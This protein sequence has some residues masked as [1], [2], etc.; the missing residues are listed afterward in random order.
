MSEFKGEKPAQNSDKNNKRQQ[1]GDANVSSPTASR[2]AV[3][4]GKIISITS[5]MKKLK[6]QKL[7]DL[8]GKL[9][10]LQLADSNK[11]N[12]NL[13]QEIKKLQI[14]DIY[15]LETQKRFVFLKQKNYEV[16]GKSAKLLA[17]KLRKQEKENTIY[18]I[19][20]LKTRI[21]RKFKRAL[22]YF[23][24]NYILNPGLQ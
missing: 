22:K 14:D 18:K 24:G 17:Y 23:T 4:R 8:Q 6:G 19:K 10:K 7:A 11:I 16:G 15:T 20:N 1:H 13:K 5:Y 21:V 9:K 2:N 3:M 12:S